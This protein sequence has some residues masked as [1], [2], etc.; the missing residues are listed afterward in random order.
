V[1]S[2]VYGL[3]FNGLFSSSV[4]VLVTGSKNFINGTTKFAAPAACTSRISPCPPSLHRACVEHDAASQRRL[5]CVADHRSL[6]VLF[7]Y[8][9]HCSGRQPHNGC[10]VTRWTSAS[11]QE[12]RHG[13]CGGSCRL[14]GLPARDEI[15]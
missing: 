1:S 3:D 2:R 11:V 12:K 15:R 13:E 14:P 4:C 10:D 8:L 9:V 5:V 6:C 7:R